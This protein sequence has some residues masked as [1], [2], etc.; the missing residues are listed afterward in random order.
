MIK[1]LD[2]GSD[3]TRA[4]QCMD[5]VEWTNAAFFTCMIG[6]TDY[7]LL[8]THGKKLGIIGSRA[9]KTMSTMP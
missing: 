9:R 2:S 1:Q 4:T 6:S 7:L 3:K 8:Q 5:V